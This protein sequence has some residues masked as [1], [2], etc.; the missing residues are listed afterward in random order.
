MAQSHEST[1]LEASAHSCCRK[2]Q[3]KSVISEF[4][5]EFY[6]LQTVQEADPPPIFFHSTGRVSLNLNQVGFLAGSK[7]NSAAHMFPCHA[8]SKK[9]INLW[10]I[11]RTTL[12][13]IQSRERAQQLAEALGCTFHRAA[14]E[15]PVQHDES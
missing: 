14:E 8:A 12:E 11:L 6:P 2:G 4:Q 13:R 5:G 15:P 7:N 1:M 10:Q 3:K 9:K